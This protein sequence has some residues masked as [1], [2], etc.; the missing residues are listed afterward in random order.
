MDKLFHPILYNG[1]NYL[2]M[3]GLKLN[4]VSKRGHGRR[5]S[6]GRLTLQVKI[7]APK[8]NQPSYCNPYI[9]WSYSGEYCSKFAFRRSFLLHVFNRTQHIWDQKLI[10]C[11][12]SDECPRA[13]GDPLTKQITHS[14]HKVQYIMTL[15]FRHYEVQCFISQILRNVCRYDDALVHCFTFLYDNSNVTTWCTLLTLQNLLKS[16]SNVARSC[17]C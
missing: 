7:Q 8:I 6:R 17:F 3:L 2:S 11:V 14:A 16:H 15:S 12:P 10:N 4:H 13:N 5:I 9:Q 1:C